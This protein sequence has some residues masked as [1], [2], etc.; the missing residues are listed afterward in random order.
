MTWD[1]PTRGDPTL[2]YDNTAVAS[3]GKVQA[4]V[5][6]AHKEESCWQAVLH[7]DLRIEFPLPWSKM[8]WIDLDMAVNEEKHKHGFQVASHKFIKLNPGAEC[9]LLC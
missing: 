1:L 5:S 4:E 7:E 3:N 2:S 9:Y 6:L 8:T